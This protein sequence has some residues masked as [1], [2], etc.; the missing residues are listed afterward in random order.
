[1]ADSLQKQVASMKRGQE[2]PVLCTAISK[3]AHVSVVVAMSMD[4]NTLHHFMSVSTVSI[5]LDVLVGAIQ[6]D[7]SMVA[8]APQPSQPSL[9]VSS[10]WIP[11]CQQIQE[12][13]QAQNG[14]QLEQVSR[15]HP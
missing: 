15:V 7:I 11:L 3:P 2:S 4:G 10:A 13:Q 14:L 9:L 6:H 12:R 8:P 5:Y 1:M